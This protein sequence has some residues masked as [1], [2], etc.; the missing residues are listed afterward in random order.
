MMKTKLQCGCFIF[1]V[2]TT[3]RENIQK[4]RLLVFRI[5][6]LKQKEIPTG[7]VAKIFGYWKNNIFTSHTIIFCRISFDALMS[8]TVEH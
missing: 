2:E 6:Y 3:A 8:L 4:K 7:A 5:L 1:L